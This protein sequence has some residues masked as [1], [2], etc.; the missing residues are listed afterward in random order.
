LIITPAK[1]PPLLKANN[2]KILKI[3]SDIALPNIN[4]GSK[5]FLA[6]LNNLLFNCIP[7]IKNDT[8]AK[9]LL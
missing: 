2:N 4:L 9:Y 3:I 5:Y 1:E 6:S 8:A 7:G